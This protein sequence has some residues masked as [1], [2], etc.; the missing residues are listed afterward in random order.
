M[1][2]PHELYKMEHAILRDEL[3]NLKKC[4]VTFLSFAITA[5]SAILGLIGIANL[6]KIEDES[7]F[8]L[9]PL[10]LLIPFWWIFFDKAVTITRIVGYYRILESLIL[11]TK[12]SHDFIGWENALAKF[13]RDRSLHE[14]NI[15]EDSAREKTNPRAKSYW[16]S[17]YLIFFSLSAV[18]LGLPWVFH[19]LCGK[20]LI[21]F[22]IT[23]VAFL[24]SAVSNFIVFWKLTSGSYS[25]TRNEKIWEKILL[26]EPAKKQ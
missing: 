22:I 24:I 8:F 21:I 9:V 14:A 17:G 6:H 26:I 4:Q 23:G 7:I 13:R 25:Y 10:L 3:N 15:P 5:T 18:C 19:T 1:F 12:T 2:D 16:I 11:G 20:E